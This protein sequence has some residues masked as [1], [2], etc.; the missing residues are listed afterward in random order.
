MVHAVGSE[1]LIHQCIYNALGTSELLAV[2]NIISI[3]LNEASLGLNLALKEL[4]AERSVKE[5][6]LLERFGFSQLSPEE[7][8]S[9]ENIISIM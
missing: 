4:H 8:M 3:L 1:Q 9:S 5:I 6:A 2:I 7:T